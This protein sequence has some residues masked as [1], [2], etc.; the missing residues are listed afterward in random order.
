MKTKKLITSVKLKQVKSKEFIQQTKDN[1][2]KLGKRIV[3][4]RKQLNNMSREQLSQLSG[5]SINTLGTFHPL[6]I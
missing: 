1:K 3:G 6:G 2:Y 4:L 5:I